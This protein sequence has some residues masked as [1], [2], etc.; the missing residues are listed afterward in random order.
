MEGSLQIRSYEASDGQKRYITEVIAEQVE[1]L[2]SPENRPTEAHSAQQA[3]EQAAQAGE[4][5][6]SDDDDLPFE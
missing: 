2:G 4:M 3:A 5:P 6:E 1:F